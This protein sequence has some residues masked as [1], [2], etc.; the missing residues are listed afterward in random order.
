MATKTGVRLRLCERLISSVLLLLFLA[1]Q[2]AL[3]Q[4]TTGMILGTISDTTGAAIPGATLTLRNVDTGFTRTVSADEAGRYRA[5]QLPLGRYEVTAELAGFQTEVRT[6]ITLTVG[7]EAVVDLVLQ[8]GVVADRITVTGEAPLVETT[9]STVSYLTQDR[10]IR[11]MPL[12]GRD[13]SQLMTLSPSVANPADAQQTQ[14]F[15]G[16]GKKIS[17]SGMRATNNSYLLDGAYILD[18]SR[19]LPAGPRGALLG[20]ETVREFEVLTNPYHA[21]YGRVLGG[22]INAVSRSGN[23]EW[24]GSAY[25]YLRNDNFDAAKWE[26]NAFGR[27]KPEF[28]RNQFGGSYG[29]PIV[30]DKTFLFLAYEAM[31][32]RLNW[33]KLAIVPDEQARNGLLPGRR[34]EVNPLIRRYLGVTFPLPSPGGRNFGDGSAE[35]IFNA[36]ET[37]AD[38]F[39]QGRVDH[40]FSTNDSFFGRFTGS[41]AERTAPMGFPAFRQIMNS[42]ASFLTLGET[43]IFSPGLLNTGRFS[44]NRVAP[45]SFGT[46]PQIPADLHS[47]PSGL[48]P[49]LNVTGLTNWQGWQW[50]NDRWITNRFQFNDDVNLTRRSHALQFGGELERLQLNLNDP[51]FPFGSWDFG[52]LVDFLEAR[53]RT[54]SGSISPLHGSSVRGHRQWLFGLYVNDEWKVQPRLTLSLGLRWESYT[55]PIEVNGLQGNL[56]RLD[57]PYTTIGPMWENKSWK[58]FG[59]RIGLAWSPSA[60]G[61]TA[62]RAGFGMFYLPHDTETYRWLS[63]RVTPNPLRPDVALLHVHRYTRIDPTLF[64]DG[65]AVIDSAARVRRTLGNTEIFSH[66]GMDT[67]QA[68]QYNLQIQQQFGVSNML[69]VGYSGTRGIHLLGRGNANLP[70]PINNGTSLEFPEGTTVMNPNYDIIRYQFAGTDSW[71]NALAVSF[72]RRLAVGLEGQIAYTFSKTIS[73]SQGGYGGGV[74]GGGNS[75]AKSLAYMR[76]NKAVDANHL[77]QVLNIRYSYDLPLGRNLRGA[78]HTLVSGWQLQGII[79]A[80]SGQPFSVIRANSGFLSALGVDGSATPNLVPGFTR[81]QIIWGAPNVSKDPTGRGRYFNPEAFSLPGD[82]ELGNVGRNFLQGPGL[83]TWDF[84]LSKNFQVRE[85]TRLQFRTEM[86]NFLNRPN[87]SLPSATAF[88]GN[89]S[90]IGS[91]GVTDRTSTTARQIQFALKLTF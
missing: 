54:Y 35:F 89:G 41:R 23:N 62:I 69:S 31:R 51:A 12:Q 84:T 20:A 15:Q 40:Q 58:D 70:P 9:G 63:T 67:Q 7:R 45:V 55:V 71:Y 4:G 90:R 86:Y 27:K 16:Y 8:V 46:Y 80:Q 21:Q 39:G 65:L 88:S 52:S 56:R 79:T 32:E 61:K 30:R 24:H 25:E 76:D 36:N 14:P 37:A 66:N 29:G 1:S 91:A 19:A 13:L 33:T 2:V 85:Q 47:L 38:D 44:F 18:M 22:V 73:T 74:A 83:A 6:G 49:A 59:P 75:D 10:T 81:E 3:A 72:Q 48:P 77:P 42:N 43:H 68:L 50:V 34:V 82:R 87:F 5:P 28:K 60:S 53:P 64:P 78:A 26:D 57:D 17:I 11:E